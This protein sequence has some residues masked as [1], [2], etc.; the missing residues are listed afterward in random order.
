MGK[1]VVVGECYMEISFDRMAL[2][3]ILPPFENPLTKRPFCCV[4]SLNGIMF[5]D[6]AENYLHVL[7]LTLLGSF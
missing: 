4:G 2:M 6:R 1:P 3:A 5:V 7:R